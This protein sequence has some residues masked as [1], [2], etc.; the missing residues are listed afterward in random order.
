MIVLVKRK[1]ATNIVLATQLAGELNKANKVF[2]TPTDYKSGKISLLCNGQVMSSP[3][4]F[5]ETG[6]NQIT[7]V[8]FAP[9]SDYILRATYEEA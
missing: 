8:H 9:L 1:Q 5:T 6:V 4:D 3:E 7:F 2:T